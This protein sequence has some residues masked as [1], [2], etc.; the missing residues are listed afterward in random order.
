[1]KGSIFDVADI[2]IVHS[3]AYPNCYESEEIFINTL[4]E[5]LFDPFFSVIDIG[6]LPFKSLNSVVPELIHSSQCEL[7]Y[8]SHSRL[9]INN[10]NI[11]SINE[12]ERK[13]AVIEL[14]KGIDEAY[15]FG[16]INFQF[17]SGKWD[18]DT[19]E[20]NL[21]SLVKSTI[22]ICKYAKRKGDMPV[23]LEIFDYD[24][25]KCSLIGKSSLASKYYKLVKKECDNFGL[26]V[27]LSHIPLIKESIEQHIN[28]IRDFISYVHIGN[29]YMKNIQD[30]AYGDKHPRFGY[31]GGE[32]DIG[33]LVIFL[34]KLIEIEY[35]NT[36]RKNIISFE[37]KPQ[38]YED[39]KIV[40]ANAKR[41]LIKAW[42]LV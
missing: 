23:Y 13:K 35:I 25:D 29:A 32:N 39:P 24:F 19:K 18:F 22:E 5:L 15:K 2:G 28:P 12:V 31:P 37:I 27:D 20:Y 7:T 1:M 30:I 4:K 40:I 9:L 3:M 21:K 11:N 16:S 34:R 41:T 14:K 26:M 17:L 36:N 10:L 33:E 38:G 42:S 6:E 8:S